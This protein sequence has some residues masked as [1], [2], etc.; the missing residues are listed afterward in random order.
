MMLP[1]P[2]AGS[3]TSTPPASMKRAPRRTVQRSPLGIA[4]R[5]T[6][7]VVGDRLEPEKTADETRV[8]DARQRESHPIR[9]ITGAVLNRSSRT[10]IGG[11]P[12]RGN[13]RDDAHGL[14]GPISQYS[15]RFFAFFLVGLGFSE[16]TYA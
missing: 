9:L 10:P 6:H 3:L 2:V 13:R 14:S 7:F 16:P 4:E 11:V 15:Q 5:D 1:L 12:S 8:A